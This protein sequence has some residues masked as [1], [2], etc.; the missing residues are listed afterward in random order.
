MVQKDEIL[1]IA[2]AAQDEVAK[3]ARGYRQLCGHHAHQRWLVLPDSKFRLYW[4]GVS[5][6]LILFIA[7]TLPYRIAFVRVCSG[8]LTRGMKARLAR[9]GKQSLVEGDGMGLAECRRVIEKAGGTISVA[10]ELGDGATFTVSLPA[11][12]D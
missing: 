5:S 4:D 11:A 1:G 3:K 8:T 6:V 2:P 7:I 9:A 12:P 10:S